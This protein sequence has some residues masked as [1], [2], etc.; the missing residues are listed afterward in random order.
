MKI[1]WSQISTVLLDMDGTLLDLHFD[2]YFW[3]HYVPRVYSAK[4][5]I[6][7]GQAQ[8]HLTPLMAS[9]QGTLNWYCV[10][11]WSEQLGIDIMQ[12]KTELS[13]KIAY[14]PQAQEFLQHCRQRVKDVRLVTN[15]HR[16]VLELKAAVT[17]LDQYFDTLV[18]SHELGAPKEEQK[19]WSQLHGLNCF[20]RSSTLFIDDNEAVL[21]A[22]NGYGIGHIYSVARPDSKTGRQKESKYPMLES[23]F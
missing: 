10:D 3:H 22:A 23:F 9:H 11:F 7:R 13:H 1:E 15:G 21:D 2:N 8:K 18:C 14:R 4:H 12:H 17:G 16:K 6:E 19:F 5:Q 20:E